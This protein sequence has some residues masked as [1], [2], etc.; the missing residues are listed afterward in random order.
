M[1]IKRPKLKF[2]KGNTYVIDQSDASNANHPLRFTADSG[3]TEYTHG[4]TATGTPG[5]AGAQVT[6]NVPDSAP[7]NIM[8]YCST[9]G[10][11][12]GNHLKTFAGPPPFVWGGARGLIAGGLTYP[13]GNIDNIDY[14]NISAPGNA[15][16]FGDL[17]TAR[18]LGASMSN[19]TRAAFAGGSISGG[20]SNTIDYVT[21]ASTGDAVDFGNLSNGYTYAAGEGDGTYGVMAGGFRY[22]GSSYYMDM[23]YITMDTPSNTTAFGNLSGNQ[24]GRAMGTDGT[25]GVIA[26]GNDGV[27]PNSKSIGMLTITMATPGNAVTSSGTLLDDHSYL[28]GM[29]GD[30]TY[31]LTGGGRR[32]NGEYAN[33]WTDMVQ[34][35][36]TATQG[37]AQDFGDLNSYGG[38]M[39]TGSDGTYAFYAGKEGLNTGSGQQGGRYNTIERISI[40]TGGNAINFGTFNNY[41]E[42]GMGS[43]G[44]AA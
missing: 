18:Y 41:I 34:R 22:S 8:Y 32:T 24:Y 33:G 37:G 30:G 16:D 11:G 5:Q 3:A 15:I 17:Y 14:I 39:A 10:I 4:V 38:S 26:T 36:V 23:E 6:F 7:E 35:F 12:M 13:S 43:S 31:L 2:L 21:V 27:S 40:T 44:N 1:A 9:H 20:Y 25:I 42:G 19:G 28:R 29:S